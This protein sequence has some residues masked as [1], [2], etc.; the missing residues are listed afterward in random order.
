MNCETGSLSNGML[1]GGKGYSYKLMLG[2][3]DHQ[4]LTL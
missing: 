2:F 3:S 4:F 1:Y